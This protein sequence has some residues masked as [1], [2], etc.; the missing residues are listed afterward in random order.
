MDKIKE[1]VYHLEDKTY[2]V[3][4]T[5]KRIKHIIYRFKGDYFAVSC[6]HLVSQK[7]VIAG[8][9]KFFVQ[10]TAKKRVKPSPIENDYFYCLGKKISISTI[11]IS[12]EEYCLKI[13]KQTLEERVRLYE[14]I[15]NISKPYKVKIK[16]MKTR[17]GTN[18]RRTHSLAFQTG[19][20][21]Y[22]IDIIDSIVVHEL[23]HF[24]VFNHSKAFYEIVYKYC[25]NYKL[26]Q[27]KL[28]KGEYQ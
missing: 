21:H 8:L 3:I 13:A 23:A 25:P 27:R 7:F 6:P 22:S 10:L 19:I 11:N 24:F 26:L 28:K 9:D 4:I 12:V 20:I 14:G 15:M 18:S 17:Y 16:K 1:I 2:K 5:Y